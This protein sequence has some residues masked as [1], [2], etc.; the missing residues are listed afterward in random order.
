MSEEAVE[1]IRLYEMARFGGK[2]LSND[3]K[4]NTNQ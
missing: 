3:E 1:F 2:E 4:K